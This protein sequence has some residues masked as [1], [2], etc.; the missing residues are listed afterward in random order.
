MK[1]KTQVVMAIATMLMA[2]AAVA[3]IYIDFNLEAQLNDKSSTTGYSALV[4]KA[5]GFKTAMGRAIR[6]DQRAWIKYRDLECSSHQRPADQANCGRATTLAQIAKIDQLVSQPEKL[7]YNRELRPPA[8]SADVELSKLSYGKC[9]NAAIRAVVNTGYGTQAKFEY[10][11]GKVNNVE[12]PD[13]NNPSVDLNADHKWDFFAIDCG[14]IKRTER[15]CEFHVHFQDD[16]NCAGAVVNSS[17][18][19]LNY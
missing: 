16:V 4:K 11:S 13:Q 5:G 8:L 10:Y 14:V 12:E 17:G 6:D 19:A 1:A 9:I 15:V 3:Q 2:T 18:G 7:S